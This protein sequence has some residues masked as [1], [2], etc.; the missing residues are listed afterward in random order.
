MPHWRITKVGDSIREFS[1]EKG[2][3]FKSYRI[4]VETVDGSPAPPRQQA[5]YE[6]VELVQKAATAAPTVGEIEGDV[7]IRKYGANNEKEDLKFQKPRGGGFGGG[8]GGGAKA[9]PPH[10]EGA[11]VRQHSQEMALRFVSAAGG[12]DDF[13]PLGEGEEHEA[14]L[15]KILNRIR[16]IADFFDKDVEARARYVREVGEWPTPATPPVRRAHAE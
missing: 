8:G 5:K 11:V 7:T 3:D 15:G 12:L 9:W 14:A 1:T 10:K 4:D 16:K 2:G 13:D 6:R